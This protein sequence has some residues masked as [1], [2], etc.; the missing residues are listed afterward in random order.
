MRCEEENHMMRTSVVGVGL[1]FYVQDNAAG[2]QTK[3]EGVASL[4]RILFCGANS[5]AAF[6]FGPRSFI[7]DRFLPLFPA[8]LS[9]S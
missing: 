6:R 9:A 3:R 2:A 4:V 5:A 7:E 1:R 8:Q